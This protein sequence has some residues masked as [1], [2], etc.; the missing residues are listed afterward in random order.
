ML[1][2]FRLKAKPDG[3]KDL[4]NGIKTDM[5]GALGGSVG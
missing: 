5:A 3:N 4:E 1:E 2:R